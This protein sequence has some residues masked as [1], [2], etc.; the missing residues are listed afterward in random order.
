MSIALDRF[1]EMVGHGGGCSRQRVVVADQGRL[2]VRVECGCGKKWS[3][4]LFYSELKK[5]QPEGYVE[6]FFKNEFARD[7][8][9][10]FLNGVLLVEYE[11]VL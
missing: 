1:N 8:L 6:R 4:K 7:R 9:G 5:G 10:A 11:E 2:E 3:W